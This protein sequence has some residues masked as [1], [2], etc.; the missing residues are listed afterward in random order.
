MTDSGNIAPLA[1]LKAQAKR[2]RDRLRGT[3]LQLSH[4]ESL[5]LVAHQH[6]VR[7]WNTL[8]A[9]AGN[10][11]QLRVGDRVQGRYLGQPFTAEI[12]GLTTL[13]DGAH[14]RITLHFDEPVDV[15]TFDSFSSYRQRVS[16]EIGWD[17]RSP[18]RTSDG[19]PQLVVRPI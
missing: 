14:R 18:R 13:G 11:M 5:E 7:D 2:L 1:E 4:G 6:G 3:G 16:G 17:G 10:R 8:H 15:V 12:R 19:E 9:M